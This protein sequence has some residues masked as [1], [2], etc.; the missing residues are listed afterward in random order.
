MFVSNRAV[1]LEKEFLRER[2]NAYKI[3]LDEVQEVEGRT[4]I[5]LDLI[6]ESNLEPIRTSL[7][8]SDRIPR[9]PNGY[10]NFLIQDGN[11]IELDENDKDPITYMEAMQRS[12]SQK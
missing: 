11:P 3:K 6:G 12:D 10:Y 2:A 1:F 4:Y 9:Q 5:E 7:R 8:R